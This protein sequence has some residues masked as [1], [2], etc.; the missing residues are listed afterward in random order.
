M[1]WRFT[2]SKFKN[3]TPKLPKKEDT[4]F[5]VPIGNLSCTDNGIQAS[6]EFLA[7]HIEGEGGKLGVLPVGAKGRRTRNDIW[8][9]AAHGEQVSDFNFLTFADNFLATCSRD[10]PVKIWKL[11]RDASP[12]L[13]TEIDAGPGVH[14]ETLKSHSTADNILAIGSIGGAFIVDVSSRKTCMELGGVVDKCQS[15]DWSDDGRLLAVSGDKGRQLL[16]FDPRASQ[17][18]I[19]QLESHAGMGREARVLFAGN[20]LISTGFTNK[21]CQEV[22][23]FDTSKW[24]SPIHVQEFVST[25]GVLIPHYDADTRL[26]FLSGKG[27]NKLFMME[28]QD[29][30]PF[31][32]SVFELTLP[33]QTLGAALGCKRR[34]SVMD[35]EVDTYYQL[36]KS[37]IVPTPCIVPRRSYR[38]FHADLFPDTR[39]AEPGC[40]AHEWLNGN[41]SLPPKMSLAP[42]TSS[43]PPPQ[44]PTPPAQQATAPPKPMAVSATNMPNVAKNPRDDVKELDYGKENG[45][46]AYQTASV[47]PSSLNLDES[48]AHTPNPP[49]SSTQGNSSPLTTTS[50]DPITIVGSGVGT[51]SHSTSGASCSVSTPSHVEKSSSAAA[52][53]ASTSTAVNFRKIGASNRSHLSQRV[54]PKSCVVGQITSKFRHV[55]TLAGLKANNGL[56]SNL[57]NVN[58]RLPQESNGCC[59]SGKFVA[60]PL[61]GPAG[62]VGIYD[63]NAPGKLADGVMDG[64]FNKTQVTDL[65]WNPFDDEQL[66]CGTD[67]GQINLWRLTTNDGHRNEMQPERIIKIG[68][69]KIVCLRWHPLAEGLVA[70]ALSN[71]NIELWDVVEEKLYARIA[72]H[73]GG[74]LAICWSADGRRL[75][76]VGKDAMVRVHEPTTSSECVVERK[77]LESTRAA[78]VLFACDDRLLIVVG[79]T[80]SSQRQV[81]MY[82][83]TM[84]D[85][86][87]IY[88]Q[89]IDSATQPLV[90]HYDYD[91]NVLFLSGKGDRIV[92]MFE[93][94]YDSPY[95]LPLTPYMSPVGGQAIAFHNKK[96]ANVMAVEFQVA[97]RLSEKNLERLIFRVPRIKK[98]VFQDD[99]FPDALVTWQPVTTAARWMAG[100]EANPMFRSLKPEGVFSSIPRPI[101]ASSTSRF[102]EAVKSTTSTTTASTTTTPRTLQSC[103]AE[104]A[105]PDRQQVA[106]SWSS[107]INV[108]QRLEQDLMEGVDESEWK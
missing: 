55:E 9:V 86:R 14:I 10:E 97:W 4:I 83:A 6:G 101:G 104:S 23:L 33:E 63:V 102:S 89:I 53:A 26:V 87:H 94:I 75:A 82:D 18:A 57:R 85:F 92:N 44:E 31:M 13:V 108:D 45:A 37:T 65:Q 79:M 5:D 59:C 61:A 25:T 74:I 72:A 100:E 70:V 2:A 105:T 42:K 54:R 17:H 21:R 71:S 22:R 30:Q 106:A 67:C 91:S 3:T 84:P 46:R 20:R 36:T 24:S 77:V 68:G 58:T 56:F 27:T 43:P 66:A 52:A 12:H 93:V 90:P 96:S 40:S 88:T 8:V 29:R 1:A 11:S 47:P 80:K 35:G 39:G 62:V 76:S 73:D 50:P 48:K 7:F 107:K 95:L 69:E 34:I 99:L 98:D 16:V 49:T 78:R 41:N 19:A 81:Q 60:V 32:S 15:L 28:L 38:D 64:I 51:R 103:A